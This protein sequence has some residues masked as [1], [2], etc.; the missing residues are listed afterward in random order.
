MIVGDR[1]LIRD[2]I[3]HRGLYEE[4]ACICFVIRDGQ[5]DRPDKN[6]GE[7]GNANKDRKNV[8]E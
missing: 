5:Y 4:E 8:E 7:E 1:I 3:T 2:N 6:V